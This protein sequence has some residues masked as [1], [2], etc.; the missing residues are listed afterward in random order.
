MS[1]SFFRAFFWVPAVLSM[2]AGPA[3][4][5]DSYTSPSGL[6]RLDIYGEGESFSSP[7]L[8]EN[9][10]E[11]Q[12]SLHTLSSWQKDSLLFAISYWDDLLRR[13]DKPDN[14]A[15][16]A[17]I[18]DDDENASA[19]GIP[20]TVRI[21][22]E[23]TI[24]RAPNRIINHN[25]EINDTIAA[26]VEIGS[27][28]F[29]VGQ[30]SSDFK[31]PLPQGRNINLAA[32]MTHEIGHAM[33][34]STDNE[35]EKEDAI[36]QFDEDRSAFDSHL[37]DW[38]GQKAEPG[39][40]IRTIGHKEATGTYFDLPGYWGGKG[41]KL[42]YFS[43]P[44]VLEVLDGAKLT[45]YDTFGK[46]TGQQPV[47]GLPINGN[48]AQDSDDKDDADL[49]HIELRNSLMSHQQWR[50]YVS[51]MEAELAL[52]QDIGY[53]IDRRDYYGRSIYG[54]GGSIVNT[55]PFFA[56]NAEGTAYVDGTFNRRMFGVGLHVYGSGNAVR[57]EAPL[58]TKGIAGVGIRVDGS[59][60]SVT[61]GR[62]TRVWADGLNG[63][64]ILV[65]YGKNHRVTIE[66]GAS[67]RALGE[68]GIGAA[69]DFGSNMMGLSSGGR[70]SWAAQ[71]AEEKQD[72]SSVDVN[73]PLVS[74]FTVRGELAGSDA[75]IRIGS[76]AFVRKIRIGEG[77]SV[78]GDIVS[79]W[80]YDDRKL[81]KTLGFAYGFDMHRQYA[82]SGELVTDLSFEGSG[83]SYDG[84]IT[85]QDNMRLDVSGSLAYAGTASVLSAT[86]R[87]GAV[88]SGGTYRP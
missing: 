85:G 57:Q 3:G 80:I 39:M 12:K 48:E 22:G 21:G 27:K 73:G 42:P 56:R 33:G 9:S 75:A 1:I 50:N 63:N 70:A 81:E 49:A 43:G 37:Y 68:G 6:F 16:F 55:A 88:L 83:L 67:V 8:K 34:I 72:A 29:P 32:T 84:D 13:S 77:A 19:G 58:L 79:D 28:L 7:F 47:P 30:Q 86:V 52:L 4:A 74:E 78:S 26:S 10:P 14:P 51:F 61:V 76:G 2:L 5:F 40:K 54:D 46:K 53:R 82:G 18:M 36:F 25:R 23:K 24:V 38:R 62:G 66:N 45:V 87:K 31:T 17:T 11:R 44:H 35:Q 15:I 59:G 69:F 41:M 64:G 71:T 65:S 60:N 20:C